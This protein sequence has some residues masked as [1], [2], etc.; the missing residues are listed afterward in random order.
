MH[1]TEILV[2]QKFWS[3]GPK[4]PRDIGPGDRNCALHEMVRIGDNSPVQIRNNIRDF[5]PPG[6]K[7]PGPKFRW[8]ASLVHDPATSFFMLHEQLL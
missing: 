3:G 4:P 8:H 6:P 5:G 2:G 1:V 7:S